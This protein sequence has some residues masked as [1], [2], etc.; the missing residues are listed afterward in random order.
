M[1]I[2][3]ITCVVFAL[4]IISCNDKKNN[5]AK[6][7]KAV[8]IV[9]DAPVVKKT[10]GIGM[11]SLG[12][13]NDIQNIIAQGWEMEDDLT[14]LM[15]AKDDGGLM[16]SFRSFYLCP[17]NTFVKNPRNSI[18]FG[19]WEYN[20]DKKTLRLRYEDGGADLYK[21]RAIASDELKLTDEGMNSITILKYVSTGM[22]QVN[23]ENDPFY[24]GNNRWRKKSSRPETDA[25]IRKRLLD[26][27]H[28]F[29][30]YY[31]DAIAKDSKT[32][33]FYGL[34]CCLKFYGP[35]IF[36]QKKTKLDPAWIDC[37]Y[38]EGQAIKAYDIMDK[39]IEKKYTWPR[40]S[41]MNWVEKNAVVLE[42]M[43]NNL[44]NSQ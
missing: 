15:D 22:R 38:D 6:D 41:E 12:E 7:E 8:T 26:C 25:A 40:G 27:I 3:K 16:M 39:I 14:D 29:I 20:D 37:F 24:A 31:K 32:V 9:E 18:Q 34:P 1:N 10:K 43:Y 35:G 13:S 44:V 28:F 5:A 11:L 23:K 17:D 4:L 33:S 42:Q 30:L 36:M 19:K 2:I 21:I